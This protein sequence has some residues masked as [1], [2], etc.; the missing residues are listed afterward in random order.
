MKFQTVD[1]TMGVGIET[2]RDVKRRKESGG[3]ASA[4]EAGRGEV[5]R[6]SN[7]SWGGTDETSVG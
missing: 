7:L 4:G 3:A 2:E 5:Q 6:N 1:G